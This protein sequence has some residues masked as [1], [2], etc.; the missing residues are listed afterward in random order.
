MGYLISCKNCRDAQGKESYASTLLL[1]IG[2]KVRYKEIMGSK[3]NSIWP[4]PCTRLDSYTPK[5]N[6]PFG[7]FFTEKSENEVFKQR[8]RF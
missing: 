8:L 1:K 7:E 2:N 3:G 6:N 5:T 4:N